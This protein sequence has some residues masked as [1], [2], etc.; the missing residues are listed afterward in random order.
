MKA[1]IKKLW[2]KALT[3]GKYGQTKNAL[4]REGRFCCLGVLCDLHAKATGGKWVKGVFGDERYYKGSHD[5]LPASVMKWAGLK[6]DNGEFRTEDG[7][8]D[9]LSNLNDEGKRFP[10]IAAAIKKYL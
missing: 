8:I 2:L 10:T 3:G 7:N 6:T 9:T 5:F 1:E 4:H